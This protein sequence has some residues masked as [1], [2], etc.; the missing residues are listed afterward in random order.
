MTQIYNYPK[1]LA[2]KMLNLLRNAFDVVSRRPP[3]ATEAWKSW[4]ARINQASSPKVIFDVGA[5]RGQT[6]EW[7]RPLFPKARIYA[8]EPLP[9]PFKNLEAIAMRDNLVSPVNAALGNIDEV[10]KIYI[11]SSDTTSSFLKNSEK[12]AQFAPEHMVQPRGCCDVKI[13]RLDEFCDRSGIEEIDILKID[14]QG[15]EKNILIGAGDMLRPS[16]I[17]SVYLEI[18]F[19]KYYDEQPDAGELFSLLEGKG[20]RLYGFSAVSFDAENGWKW[21]DAMFV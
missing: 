8:F 18:M 2:R 7:F 16:K 12:I 21:A 1:L 9:E 3:E 11:N 13:E 4:A 15:Y 10:K 14:A 5:N 6:I 19:A 20:Y 17:K